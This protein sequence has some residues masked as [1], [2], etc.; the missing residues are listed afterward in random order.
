M[1]FDLTRIIIHVTTFAIAFVF[2]SF[3]KKQNF[4]WFMFSGLSLLFYT[5][6]V[7]H[8]AWVIVWGVVLTAL[9]FVAK[10]MGWPGT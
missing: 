8:V 2:F 5:Y 10:R 9:P 6:F 3:G 4:F 1:D 7:D